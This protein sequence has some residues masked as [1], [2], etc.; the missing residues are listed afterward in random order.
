MP[1]TVNKELL[2]KILNGT[3]IFMMV[4]SALLIVHLWFSFKFLKQ[5]NYLFEPN[6]NIGEA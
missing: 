3:L 4:N 2:F 6:D 5:F 1:K